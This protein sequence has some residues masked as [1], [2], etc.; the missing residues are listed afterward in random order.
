MRKFLRFIVKGE[1]ECK[2]GTSP[3]TP[4]AHSFDKKKEGLG[5][6]TKNPFKLQRRF[7][8]DKVR[9]VEEK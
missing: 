9:V 4:H 8:L 5:T 3:P 2:L 6:V 1:L 7:L